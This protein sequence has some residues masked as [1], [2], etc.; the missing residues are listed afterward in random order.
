MVNG[1][2]WVSVEDEDV[3]TVVCHSGLLIPGNIVCHSGFV[4]N[5]CVC[6]CAHTHTPSP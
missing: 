2:W 6:V 4:F 5:L 1:E 3:I